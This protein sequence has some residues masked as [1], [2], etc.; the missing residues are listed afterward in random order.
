LGVAGEL[1]LPSLR[2]AQADK[3]IAAIPPII[4]LENLLVSD[5]ELFKSEMSF[6]VLGKV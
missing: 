4:S 3:K 5:V 1:E 6:T 2:V